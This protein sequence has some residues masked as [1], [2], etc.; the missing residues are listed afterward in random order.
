MSLE[1]G[2]YR[3][4]RELGRG[5]MGVVYQAFDTVLEREVAIKTI[6]SSLRDE[7]LKERFIREARA[8]AKLLHPNIITIYDFG[9]QEDRLFISMEYVE[10]SDLLDLINS[11]PALDIRQRLEIVRQICLGLDFAHARGVFHRDVKPANIR[12]DQNSRV[13]IVDF[14]LAVIQTSSLTRSNAILGTPSYI[15]PE[16]LL[17]GPSDARSDQFAV[18]IILF[19]MLTYTKAFQGENISLVI[20][21]ILHRE[22][23]ALNRDFIAS[24]PELN[25][26]LLKAIHKNPEERYSSLAGMAADLQAVIERMTGDGFSLNGPVGLDDADTPPGSAGEKTEMTPSPFSVRS[27][28]TSGRK[29]FRAGTRQLFAAALL[30]LVAGLAAAWIFLGRDRAGPQAAAGTLLFEVRPYA[31][32]REIFDLTANQVFQSEL[33]A[34]PRPTPLRLVLPPGRYRISYDHPDW[35]GVSRVLETEVQAGRVAFYADSLGE[36][37]VRQAVGHY[38]LP[39]DLPFFEE[40]GE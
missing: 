37:F 18:G 11:R 16:R 25:A 6:A 22:P 15:A 27:Q 30:L 1:F 3:L 19:E 21:S 10:G 24:Y 4:E 40:I 23:P 5:A 39:L 33:F 20:N 14:G 17:G 2:R 29:A 8:A 9:L 36:D 35:G 13:K 31:L 28:K 34:L 12:L 26:I 38:A 32:V 7:D